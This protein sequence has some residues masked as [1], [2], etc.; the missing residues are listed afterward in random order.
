MSG[1]KF[2]ACKTLK[3]DES[4]V[5]KYLFQLYFVQI[6]LFN[7]IDMLCIRT[8]F[9]VAYFLFFFLFVRL[10]SKEAQIYLWDANERC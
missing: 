3:Q 4:V 1:R 7:G 9:D 8:V 6:D 10:T 2:S 5:S